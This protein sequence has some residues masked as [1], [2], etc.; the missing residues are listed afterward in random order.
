MIE[1]NLPNEDAP[2]GHYHAW[3][4]Q[5]HAEL[6]GTSIYKDQNGNSVHITEVGTSSKPSSS[7]EDLQY[8][9]IVVEG[10]TRGRKGKE[11]N[12]QFQ[13]S[14]KEFYD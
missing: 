12:Q 14:L 13:K 5:K 3:Y 8:Q 9:G 11:K 2:K 6:N 7:W 1:Q 10:W 4:S